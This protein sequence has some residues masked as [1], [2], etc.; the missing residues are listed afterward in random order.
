MVDREGVRT[1]TRYTHEQSRARSVAVSRAKSEPRGQQAVEV[2][3]RR[4]YLRDEAVLR[5]ASE[6]TPRKA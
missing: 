1:H 3:G 4:V 2:K 5:K 6:I